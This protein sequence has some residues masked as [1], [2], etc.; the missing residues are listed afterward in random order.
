MIPVICLQCRSL[1]DGTTKFLDKF[2]KQ[3]LELVF[4]GLSAIMLLLLALVILLLVSVVLLLIW[5]VMFV[6]ITIVCS[7]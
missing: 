1:H 2:R 3:P 7:R 5:L 4:L 6:A